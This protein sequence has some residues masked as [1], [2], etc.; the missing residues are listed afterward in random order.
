VADVTRIAAALRRD[1]AALR[2]VAPTVMIVEISGSPE[3]R[4]PDVA[5]IAGGK[6]P[7]RD[8]ET[9]EAFYARLRGMAAALLTK[10]DKRAAVV[11]IDIDT[12]HSEIAAI[13]A[14]VRGR[15]DFEVATRR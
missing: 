14:E 3:R 7:K 5:T 6:Y 13:E 11:C 15:S 10:G 8:G 12:P 9:R 1:V 4:S 2:V